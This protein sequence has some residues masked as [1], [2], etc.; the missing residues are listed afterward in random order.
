D[1]AG[2]GTPSGRENMK[3]D[4]HV[5]P[6]LLKRV[7]FNH[8]Q[9]RELGVGWSAGDHRCLFKFKWRSF[10]FFPVVRSQHEKVCVGFLRLWADRHYPQR[11]ARWIDQGIKVIVVEQ[12]DGPASQPVG[13]RIGM[14][15]DRGFDIVEAGWKGSFDFLILPK[16]LDN[17]EHGI[18][19]WYFGFCAPLCGIG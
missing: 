19:L 14:F 1:A 6:L 9:H 4:S 7:L 11:T 12:Y 13:G 8:A 15:P 2:A 3:E 5:L 16:P 10:P 17:C 18:N